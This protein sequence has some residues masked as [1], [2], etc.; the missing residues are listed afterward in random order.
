MPRQGL[1]TRRVVDEAASIADAD[2]LDAGHARAGRGGARR[3]GAVALQPRRRPRRR[4]CGCWPCAESTSWA[5]CCATRPWGA[6]A[7][8]RCGRSPT[9]TARTRTR[10]PGLLCGDRP[11]A[12]A[13]RRRAGGSRARER[14]TC[15]VAVLAAWGLDRRR[16]AAPRARD[17]RRAARVRDDRGRGRLRPAARPRSIIR[18][19]ARDARRRPREELTSRRARGSAAAATRNACQRAGPRRAQLRVPRV[20]PPIVGSSRITAGFALGLGSDALSA[21]ESFSTT[22]RS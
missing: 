21:V 19:A 10:H 6:P 16:G 18:A 12:G 2:G 17:P 3:P 7:T 13:R 15:C 4:C 9:P 1:D 11:R 14:S 20:S 8:M 22:P 5:T